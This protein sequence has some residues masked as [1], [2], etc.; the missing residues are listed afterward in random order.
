MLLDILF[1]AVLIILSIHKGIREYY[2]LADQGFSKSPFSVVE[3]ET[4]DSSAVLTNCAPE[5]PAATIAEAP[6]AAVKDEPPD[7]RRYVVPWPGSKYHIFLDGTDQVICSHDDGKLH[8]CD[9]DKDDLQ[10]HTW[11][12]VEKEGYFG[13]F[14]THTGRFIGHG[15]DG[16]MHSTAKNHRGWE[17]ITV[18]RH[19]E[20]GYELLMPYWSHT[21]KK[22]RVFDGSKTVVLKRYGTTRWQFVK[23][24]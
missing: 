2:S 1:Q 12:C 23:A 7:G 19:P 20:G 13:F 24:K 14:N 11:V 21:L 9:A 4:D 10:L 3:K 18:R 5:T 8:L 17:L 16:W 6:V 22:V 15:N